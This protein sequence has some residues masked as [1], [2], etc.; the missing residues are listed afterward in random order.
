MRSRQTRWLTALATVPT[1]LMT[2]AMVGPLSVQAA[3]AGVYAHGWA[4]DRIGVARGMPGLIAGDL[5]DELPL[6]LKDLS[7]R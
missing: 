7:C 3:A 5:L 4:A 6:V 1:V 2:L